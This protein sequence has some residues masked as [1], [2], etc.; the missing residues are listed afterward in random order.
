MRS[1]QTSDL[2]LRDAERRPAIRALRLV[3]P[4]DRLTPPATVLRPAPLSTGGAAR[5]IR[6]YA[7]DAALT[8]SRDC[9]A[10][11]G[12]IP[13]LLRELA[14]DGPGITTAVAKPCAAGWPR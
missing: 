6:R 14:E 2:R 9:H 10:A 8:M 11:V 13:W 3:D 4:P 5:L 1:H 7:P 12:G